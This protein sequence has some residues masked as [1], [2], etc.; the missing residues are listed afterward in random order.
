MCDCN[1]TCRCD[2]C[3]TKSITSDLTSLKSP[4]TGNVVGDRILLFRKNIIIGD[5][6]FVFSESQFLNA[7]GNPLV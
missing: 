4:I 5:I 6:P 3:I 2:D 7:F 1:N